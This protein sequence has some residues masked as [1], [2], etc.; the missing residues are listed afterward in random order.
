MSMLR[1]LGQ[2]GIK[3]WNHIFSLLV[4]LQVLLSAS[5]MYPSA[6]EQV[7]DPF[8]LVHVCEHMPGG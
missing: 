7:Y 2:R 6:Q 5:K 3:Y 4:A 8:V 1:G